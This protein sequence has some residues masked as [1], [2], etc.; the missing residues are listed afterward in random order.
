VSEAAR[1]SAPQQTAPATK[2]PAVVSLQHVRKIDADALCMVFLGHSLGKMG[3]Q[4]AHIG[5]RSGRSWRRLIAMAICHTLLIQTFLLGLIGA[6]LVSAATGNGM[7]DFE[8]CLSSGHGAP[9]VPDK[10]P[11]YHA[12]QPCALCLCGADVSLAPLPQSS[13]RYVSFE[14]GRGRQ[15]ADD[16]RQPQSVRYL[17]ARPRGPP[18][19]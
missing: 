17:T 2:T 15:V 19:A 11:D 4:A 14:A 5:T 13:F 16:A 7:P 10:A 8:V 3:D 18:G 6:Q 12:V 9:P 1:H